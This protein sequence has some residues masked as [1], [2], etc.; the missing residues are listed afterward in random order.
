MSKEDLSSETV[1]SSEIA[2]SLDTER[3][4]F[5]VQFR[6]GSLLS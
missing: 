6:L 5:A 3:L 4:A 1:H 2:Q